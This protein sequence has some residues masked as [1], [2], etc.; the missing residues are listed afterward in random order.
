MDHYSFL[1]EI[2]FKVTFILKSYDIKKR[3]IVYTNH[4]TFSNII[5]DL[6]IACTCVSGPQKFLAG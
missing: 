2:P 5:F 4:E 3:L 1:K 6:F